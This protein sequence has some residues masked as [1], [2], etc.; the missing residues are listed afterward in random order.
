MAVARGG[1]VSL[2]CADPVALAEFWAAMLGGEIMFTS[3]TTADIRTEWV[4]LSAMKI[5]DYLPA[6]WP[7]GDVP[8]QIHLGLA[9]TDLEAAAAAAERLGARIAPVQ[10]APDRWR[11]LFD[12][13]G[14]PFCLTT[15]NPPEAQ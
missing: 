13:A 14:H 10:P 15:Q 6:T 11:A 12:L 2:D 7:A 8:K 5:P 3:A 4:W 1:F 9:V